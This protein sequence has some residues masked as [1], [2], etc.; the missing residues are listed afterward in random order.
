MQRVCG[1]DGIQALELDT[2]GPGI[3]KHGNGFLEHAR[4]YEGSHFDMIHFETQRMGGSGSGKRQIEDFKIMCHDIRDDTWTDMS[5]ISVGESAWIRRALHDA[6]GIVRAHKTNTKFLTGCSDESDAALDPEA[7]P[8]YVRMLERAH[9]ESGRY[10][11]VI[12][13]HSSEVQDMIGQKIN[14]DEL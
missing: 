11:T 8:Y 12:I 5:L 13:T 6:F 4:D 10:Q 9:N 3:E 2:A 7:R 14:M 1:P